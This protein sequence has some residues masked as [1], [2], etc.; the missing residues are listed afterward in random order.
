MLKN[1]PPPQGKQ[2]AGERALRAYMDQPDA[3]RH[4][5]EFRLVYLQ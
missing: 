5:L 2:G 1:S 4:A 3:N